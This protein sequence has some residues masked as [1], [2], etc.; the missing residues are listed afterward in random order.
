MFDQVLITWYENERQRDRSEGVSTKTR[1]W[2]G[3]TPASSRVGGH[4]YI[5]REA[6]QNHHNGLMHV[7]ACIV[8]QRGGQ[9]TLMGDVNGCG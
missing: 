5:E 4:T 3:E 9:G 2:V 6:H 7:P 8:V 1:L